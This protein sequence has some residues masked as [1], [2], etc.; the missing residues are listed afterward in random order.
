MS[1][2]WIRISHCSNIELRR[3]SWENGS[4][5]KYFYCVCNLIGKPFRFWAKYLTICRISWSP[6]DWLFL[7]KVVANTE[8]IPRPNWSA[9][10]PGNLGNPGS[11]GNPENSDNC[12]NQYP[13]PG[14]NYNDYYNNYY[15]TYYDNYFRNYY[16]NLGYNIDKP[17]D[18][19]YAKRSSRSPRQ[20]SRRNS[21]RLTNR[22]SNNPSYAYPRSDYSS[23]GCRGC[24]AYPFEQTGNQ[25]WRSKFDVSTEFFLSVF[26]HY[27]L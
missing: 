13:S 23:C 11:A 10:Y 6:F 22:Y 3:T 4:L 8:S 2:W 7:L 14:I 1:F 20:N 18:G 26:Y 25:I 12:D 21:P 27:F 24:N 19:S 15:R 9:G 16:K 17:S 5:N